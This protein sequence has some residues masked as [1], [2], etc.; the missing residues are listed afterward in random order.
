MFCD[1]T[2]YAATDMPSS[3][4]S[5]QIATQTQSLLVALPAISAAM[6]AFVEP[7][8]GW[9]I[10]SA[11]RTL[12]R[13]LPWLGLVVLAIAPIAVALIYPELLEPAAF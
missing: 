5:M 8:G 13:W 7:A 3:G 11:R 10:R 2:L 4:G 1:G 6:L 9:P 12:P